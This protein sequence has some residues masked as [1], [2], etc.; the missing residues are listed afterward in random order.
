MRD[1]AP[2]QL[3][4]EKQTATRTKYERPSQNLLPTRQN[5]LVVAVRRGGRP[6]QVLFLAGL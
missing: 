1:S 2:R 4:S 6:S 5:T 3:L